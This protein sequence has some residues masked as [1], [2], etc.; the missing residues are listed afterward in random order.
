MTGRTLLSLSA[1]LIH[2]L[3][4][5]YLDSFCLHLILCSFIVFYVSCFLRSNFVRSP[6]CI[7]W[8]I[9]ALKNISVILFK[10]YLGNR[11]HFL[12]GFYALYTTTI[13]FPTFNTL[14]WLLDH[15]F[16]LTRILNIL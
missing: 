1:V 13:E 14:G 12:H 2:E 5:V 16:H 8:V 7:T 6:P 15:C 9:V 11:F 4:F 10:L 3:V